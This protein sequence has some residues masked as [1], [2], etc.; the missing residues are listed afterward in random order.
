MFLF[1]LKTH[2]VWNDFTDHGR[3]FWLFWSSTLLGFRPS[4]SGFL[5]SRKGLFPSWTTLSMDFSRLIS[6]SRSSWRIWTEAR[7]LSLTILGKSRKSTQLLG[8]PLMSYP[9]SLLNLLGSFPRALCINTACST[10]SVSGVSDELA[11]Y[12]QG[13]HNIYL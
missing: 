6:S 11:P 3:H 13:E 8:W 12:L 4:N 1:L 2:Q 7:I 9:L 10:C 5:I